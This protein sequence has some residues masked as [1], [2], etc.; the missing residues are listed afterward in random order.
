MTFHHP[1][2]IQYPC[3]WHE[4]SR[5]ESRLCKHLP[6]PS[7]QEA[8]FLRPSGPS[9]A[10]TS[11]SFHSTKNPFIT[12]TLWE[13]VLRK[14]FLRSSTLRS[15]TLRHL[16]MPSYARISSIRSRC[17]REEVY[18]CPEASWWNMLL[19]QP[20]TS[21]V[22][23]LHQEMDP[24]GVVPVP[25]PVG[26]LAKFTHA[27]WRPR[28][29]S[30]CIRTRDLVHL[31]D[32]G[33]LAPGVEPFLMWSGREFVWEVDRE[34][35]LLQGGV[36]RDMLGRFDV[37]VNVKAE[38]VMVGGV[39]ESLGGGKATFG[40]WAQSRDVMLL[41]RP[42]C[43]RQILYTPF[44]IL[45]STNPLYIIPNPTLSPQRTYPKTALGVAL[46]HVNTETY[47]TS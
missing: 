7:I 10:I 36:V 3:L 30:D 25:V 19:Q 38:E 8:L 22:R 14:R 26:A 2:R 17:K 11:P 21:F 34:M 12:E 5:L 40:G 28:A 23:L 44:L 18:M 37:V 33:A 24:G 29:G 1:S 4:H 47:Q 41:P 42:E 13:T 46:S 45:N 9:T 35:Q 39:G 16:G 31:V 43:Q 15:W 27:R 20:A 32:A 6:S